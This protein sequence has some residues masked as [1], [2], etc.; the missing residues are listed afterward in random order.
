MTQQ[1]ATE[2]SRLRSRAPALLALAA[3]L[4]VVSPGPARGQEESSLDADQLLHYPWIYSGT[5][6]GIAFSSVDLGA[7]S[8]NFLSIPI[9]FWMRRLPCCGNPITPEVEGRTFGW[10]LRVTGVIGIAEFDSIAEFDVKSVDLGAIFPGIELLF[11]T[12]QRSVLRPYVDIGWGATSTDTTTLVYGEAGLRTEFVF[13]WRTWELGIEP[14][15]SGG[16]AFTDIENADLGH[17]KISSK[18]SARYPLGFTIRGQTPDVG[19]YFDP[20]W[21]PN[22]ITFP[23]SGGEG[24]SVDVQYEL[25]VTLGFRFLAPMLCR[26]FRWPRLGIGWRFG[27]GTD[28]WHIRIGGDR[29]IRLPLP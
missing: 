22:S 29:I 28:G 12:G 2:V 8:T 13:P 15:F 1:I 25:G 24:Q 7:Q 21:Y 18:V 9:S 3:V 16:Y 17:I 26:L 19:V 4:A 5:D 27:D 23:T 20:M 14:R 11:K 10:R 6:D